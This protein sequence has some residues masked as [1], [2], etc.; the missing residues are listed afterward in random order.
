LYAQFFHAF[1][2]GFDQPS[3]LRRLLRIF[4]D[5]FGG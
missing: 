4:K 1:W 2:T 3:G 5:E